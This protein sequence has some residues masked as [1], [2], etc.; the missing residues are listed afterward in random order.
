LVL[1]RPAPGP[2]IARLVAPLEAPGWRD[3]DAGTASR[4]NGAEIQGTLIAAADRMIRMA[5]GN[6]HRIARLL[7]KFTLL[8]ATRADQV[9]DSAAAFTGR[10][11]G[12]FDRELIRNA[13]REKLHWHLSYGK[14]HPQTSL[15]PEHVARWRQLYEALALCRAKD[16]ATMGEQTLSQILGP[17][18]NRRGQN[19]A[20]T[21]GPRHPRSAGTE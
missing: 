13:L 2:G 15:R 16:R 18:T 4:P 9:M 20:G 1:R 14:H 11:A 7:D 19:L 6:A 12:V 21:T 8:D 17:F 3:D 10:D 5:I